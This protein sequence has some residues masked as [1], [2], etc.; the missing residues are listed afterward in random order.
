MGSVQIEAKVTEVG[1][2]RE[3]Q[4]FGRP[5]RVCTAR[6]KD[7]SGECSL[8]LWNE[9]V[10]QVKEGDTVVISDGYASEWQGQLQVTTGRN[11]TLEIKK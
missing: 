7:E 8:S 1:P 5:G 11:G 2:V 10:D 4:K 9:Q 6:I 3:F